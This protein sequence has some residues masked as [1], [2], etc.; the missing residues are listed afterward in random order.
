VRAD[1]Q[2]ILGVLVIALLIFIFLIARF[3]R[4]FH[5]NLR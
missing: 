5:W 4:F 1:R 2:Q 3:G